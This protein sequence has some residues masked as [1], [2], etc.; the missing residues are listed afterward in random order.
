MEFHLNIGAKIK[1]Y[2][3][4]WSGGNGKVSPKNRLLREGYLIDEGEHV[5]G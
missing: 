4:L 1:V 3:D 2:G 5:L